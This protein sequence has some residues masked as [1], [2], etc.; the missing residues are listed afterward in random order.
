MLPKVGEDSS[1]KLS[2]P[3]R[4]V[5]TDQA[6]FHVSGWKSLIDKQSRVF[7]LNR[8]LGVNIHIDGGL[9]GYSLGNISLPW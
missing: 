9:K 2:S 7:V 4:I 5:E 1:M 3:V 6:G 8:P